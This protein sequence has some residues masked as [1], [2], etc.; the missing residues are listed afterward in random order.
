MSALSMI[1]RRVLLP[2]VIVLPGDFVVRVDEEGDS[3][4]LPAGVVHGSE[5]RGKLELLLGTS[6]L[7]VTARRMPPHRQ[8]GSYYCR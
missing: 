4:Y 3:M 7:T 6:V 1:F 2:E 5:R 8:P